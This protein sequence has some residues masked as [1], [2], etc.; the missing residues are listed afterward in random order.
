MTDNTEARCV[1]CKHAGK[2]NSL[3]GM[4]YAP[5]LG[6]RGKACMCHCVFPNTQSP[7]AQPV[8]NVAQQ[9]RTAMLNRLWEIQSSRTAGETPEET[10]KMDSVLSELAAELEKVPLPKE[11][12]NSSVDEAKPSLSDRAGTLRAA[13]GV[14]VAGAL[15]K[16]QSRL[17]HIAADIA[18]MRG[19][20]SPYADDNPK[21]T[22]QAILQQAHDQQTKMKDW[23]HEIS[24]IARGL[25]KL[26]QPSASDVF[27]NPDRDKSLV[28]ETEP[29]ESSS[30]SS[31][32]EDRIW[33]RQT[34]EENSWKYGYFCHQ[35]QDDAFVEFAR[36]HPRGEGTFDWGD[37]EAIDSLYKQGGA[38]AIRLQVDATVR[39]VLE[40][41]SKGG[42]GEAQTLTVSRVIERLAHNPQVCVC[43][44][45]CVH[46][47]VWAT[48]VISEL[49]N[50]RTPSQ[51]ESE[52][53]W[54]QA[55]EAAA[56]VAE[57]DAELCEEHSTRYSAKATAY[58]IA[59]T[60]RALPPP[61]QSKQEKL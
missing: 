21:T 50:T 47:E 58:R 11:E 49:W 54:R 38:T 12:G 53:A 25:T 6:N 30:S 44:P 10:M 27:N 8:D 36:I 42:E 17:I 48:K 35:P 19:F 20:I 60:I 46:W 9:M 7:D 45:F 24:E 23:A 37:H 41:R 34:H 55:M 14:G 2:V 57:R 59:E 1:K 61:P 13:Q 15:R 51:V 26:A 56:K 32:T 39:R 3:S 5:Q 4:C 52:A 43:K 18:M 22:P 33:L 40:V 16:A 29:S 31:P 28:P